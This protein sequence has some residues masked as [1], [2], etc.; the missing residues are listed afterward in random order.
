MAFSPIRNV[1]AR[2]V[3]TLADWRGF[4]HYPADIDVENLTAFWRMTY[5]FYNA[6]RLVTR[7]EKGNDYFQMLILS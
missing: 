2:G 7:A 5:W 6:E 4:W 3:F 1:A